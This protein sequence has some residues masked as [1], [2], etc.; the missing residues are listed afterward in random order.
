MRSIRQGISQEG[1]GLKDKKLNKLHVGR[2][3]YWIYDSRKKDMEN[4][5][6]KEEF[7][8]RLTDSMLYDRLHT[9]SAEYTLS[10]ELL[11]N[12]AVK[13]LIDDINFIRDLRS[14]KIK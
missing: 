14:G 11:V 9:L 4:R 6:Q 2:K 13:R 1:E 8:I 5:V 7:V 12:I 3:T 10:V